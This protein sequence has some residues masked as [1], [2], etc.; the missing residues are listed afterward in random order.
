MVAADTGT[1][2]SS[3]FTAIPPG[4]DKSAVFLAEFPN[5]RYVANEL[6]L[7]GLSIPDWARWVMQ[8]F[9]YFLP[10]QDRC[11]AWADPNTQF[12][13][14]LANYGIDLMANTRGPEVRVEIAR[15]YFQASPPRVHLMP[16]LQVLPYELEQASWPE[17]ENSAGRY[18]R[19]KRFDHTLDC[20]EHCLSRRPRGTFLRR[21]SKKSFL[22][23][24]FDLYRR[25]D[26]Q[27]HSDV[28]LGR[29]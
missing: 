3:V 16:W 22:Q 18:M 14:E 12:K 28:H 27:M 9:H 17:H 29:H 19:V 21:Q 25:H 2:M 7:V 23:Q 15:E 13:I 20:A 1:Y 26:R 24:Q 10:R 4:D 8:G 11:K 5:Y 6:E